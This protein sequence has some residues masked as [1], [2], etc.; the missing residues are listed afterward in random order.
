MLARKAQADIVLRQEHVRDPRVRGRLVAAQPQQLRRREAGER[1]VPGQ[2]DQ[3]CKP[4]PLFDL[5]A[6][7]F[8]PLVVP[9]DRRPKHAISIVENDETV[10]LTGEPDRGRLAPERGQRLLGC[11]PPVFRILLGPPGVRRREVVALLG[12]GEHVTFCRKRERLDTR[13]ADVET[14]ELRHPPSAA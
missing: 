12:P 5:G 10:H 11:P 3:P 8:R 14:D 1:T 7:R 13:R 6:L 4:D 9:E 2:L